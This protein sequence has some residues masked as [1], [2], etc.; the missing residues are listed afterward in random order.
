M[1]TGIV[2]E[3]GTVERI[4]PTAKSIQLTV[5]ARI[6]GRGMKVSDSLAVNGC[7]L[8]VVKTAS[9]GP[10]KLLEFDLLRETWERTNLQ[11]ARVNSLVNLERSL[12]ADSRMGGHFVTGHIDGTGTIMR[13][14]RSGADWVLDVAP[15]PALKRYLVYKGAIAVDG[16]SLTVAE[17]K[18]R[19]FRIWIIPHTYEITAL[20]ERKAGDAVNLEADILGK[21]VEQ[22]LALKRIL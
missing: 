16:I 22:F 9:K 15:P 3:T 4:S 13:W 20:R 19:F 12:R 8:T 2:E 14:E 6:C 7:C 17:V 21:Y 5:R 10:D 1:F 11:F 18:P